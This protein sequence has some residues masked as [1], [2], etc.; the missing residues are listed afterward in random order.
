MIWLAFAFKGPETLLH[1]ALERTLGLYILCQIGWRGEV[2]G[3]GRRMVSL[4]VC[5]VL[6]ED[7]CAF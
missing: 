1:R 7:L 5:P 3:L 2:G 6:L 4:P